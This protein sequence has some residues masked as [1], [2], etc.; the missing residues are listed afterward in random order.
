MET[1]AMRGLVEAVWA[2]FASRNAELIAR[3]FTEDAEWIAPPGNGTAIALGAPDRIVGVAAI[4]RF[5]ATDM[6]RLFVSVRAEIR[7]LHADRNTAVVEMRLISPL[8][9][10]AR[11]ENDYCFV[12]TAR[13]GRIARM[14]EYMD[15]LTGHRQ[16][17]AQGHPLDTRMVEAART[18]H[19]RM[20]P[21]QES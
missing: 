13:D 3:H 8:P 12:F 9:N 1:E 4:A 10:G 2:A 15:T 21:L 20:K 14:R 5:I 17:F 19:N 7:G 16:L 11:Y 6:H 18:C